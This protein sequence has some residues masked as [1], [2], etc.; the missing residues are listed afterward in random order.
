MSAELRSELVRQNLNERPPNVGDVFFQVLRCDPADSTAIDFWWSQIHSRNT[1]QELK[2]LSRKPSLAAAF[3]RVAQIPAFG[4]ELVPGNIGSL[5][6]LK[7]DEE[8]AHSL[9]YTREAWT[10][11]FDGVASPEQR[12]DPQTVRTVRLRN[13]A[14]CK[15]DH[16]F[17]EPLVRRGTIFSGFDS[18]ERQVIWRNMK[19]FPGRI[20]SLAVC[21]EDFKYLEDVAGCVKT[22]FTIPRSQTLSCVLNRSFVSASFLD[23]SSVSHPRSANRISRRGQF[24]V[25]RRRLF[26]FVMRELGNLLPG[27]IMLERPGSREVVEATSQAK[28]RLAREAHRL[29]FRSIKI[30][31][32]LAT[33]P[34]RVE[35]RRSL[36]RARNPQ[37]FVY[38]ETRL[39]ALVDRLVEAYAEAQPIECDRRPCVFVDNGDGECLRRRYGRPFRR[40]FVEC[41]TLLTLENMHTS[42]SPAWGELTSLFVRRDVYL[43]FFGPL[44][45]GC[46][47]ILADSEPGSPLPAMPSRDARSPAGDEYDNCVLDDDPPRLPSDPETLDLEGVQTSAGNALVLLR[48][49]LAESEVSNHSSEQWED[50]SLARTDEMTTKPPSEPDND[51]ILFALLEDSGQ[52]MVESVS[53]DDS[54]QSVVEEIVV[55]YAERRC[56]LFDSNFRA[57]GSTQCVRAAAEEPDRTVFL[58]PEGDVRVQNLKTFGIKSQKRPASED[59]DHRPHKYHIT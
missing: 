49:G 34:D 1:I 56:G 8:V 11:L 12:L 7:C 25:A 37:R 42:W 54:V 38:D 24:D 28:Y 36:L 44:D 29:G 50:Q 27:S 5:L 3:R 20:P 59:L 16:D 6:R 10:V 14:Y 47:N 22:L 19:K 55:R 46:F 40:A 45:P 30:S 41:A 52:T 35:A 9:L 32:E 18:H 23:T 48:R 58:I 51:K 21:F 53:I 2:R 15:T 31:K 57:L 13:T 4:W 39:E 17:L 43:T 33:D 26:L